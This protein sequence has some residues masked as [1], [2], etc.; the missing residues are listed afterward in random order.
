MPP[1]KR[2]QRPGA[3]KPAAKRTKPAKA[4][5]R[6]M[7]QQGLMGAAAVVDTD[8]V[9]DGCIENA[10]PGRPYD[11]TTPLSSIPVRPDDLNNCLNS[12]LDLVEPYRYTSG[13]IQSAWTV[14]LLKTDANHR[15]LASHP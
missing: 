3:K 15:Y 7:S 13:V 4:L 6:R 8:A 14:G 1:G 10:A 5:P 2:A 12:A 9:V 11:D